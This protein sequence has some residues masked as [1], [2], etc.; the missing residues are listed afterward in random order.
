MIL[1]LAPCDTESPVRETVE[2][3]SAVPGKNNN[4]LA[5]CDPIDLL[6]SMQRAKPVRVLRLYLLCQ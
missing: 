5:L 4:R 2:A 1:E 6:K 3:Y